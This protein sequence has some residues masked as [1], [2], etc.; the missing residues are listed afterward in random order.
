MIQVSPALFN[1]ALRPMLQPPWREVAQQYRQAC[2]HASQGRD[3]EAKL[4]LEGAFAEALTRAN[5][6]APLP[7]DQLQS[8]LEAEADRVAMAATWLELVGWDGSPHPV[9]ARARERDRPDPRRVSHPAPDSLPGI[10]DLI[11][12]MLSQ[13]RAPR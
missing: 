12:D 3:A 13:D 9:T 8:A 1:I 5:A 2:W 10:A 6:I 11:D 7:D 4:I